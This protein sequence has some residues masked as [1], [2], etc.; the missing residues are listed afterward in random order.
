M[1][2][3]HSRKQPRTTGLLA[4]LCGLLHIGGIGPSKITGPD[5]TPSLKNHPPS[6]PNRNSSLLRLHRHSS[7]RRPDGE[8]RVHLADGEALR[9]TR[10]EATVNAGEEA[11]GETT[12]CHF[13]YGKT[14]VI[15]HT[16]ACEQGTPPGTLEGGEQGVA[17]TVKGLKPGTTYSYRVVLKSTSGKIEGGEEKVTT[18]PSRAPKPRVRS[19]R[20]R[21]RSMGS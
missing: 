17:A 14:S 1:T 18:L 15:E 3:E 11:A 7:R 10:L 5:A 20:R 16:V 19:A 8:R 6:N 4:T 13:Q 12:E 9:R 2:T 21:R